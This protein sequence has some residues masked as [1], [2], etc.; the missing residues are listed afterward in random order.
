MGRNLE[1]IGIESFGIGQSPETAAVTDTN[2]VAVAAD[3]DMAYCV[4]TLL[5]VSAGI[6]FMAQG[7]V[8][9]AAKGQLMVVGERRKLFGPQSVQMIVDT[10]TETATV[11]VQVFKRGFPRQ[12]DAV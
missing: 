12:G 9:E 4:V 6:V 7:V 11:A 5:S 2:S 10:A 8:S 1:E 3:D